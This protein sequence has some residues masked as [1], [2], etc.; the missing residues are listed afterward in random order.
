MAIDFPP[1]TAHPAAPAVGEKWPQPSVVGVPVYSWDGEK[2]T[3]IGGEIGSIGGADDLPLMDGVATPGVST[4]WA[5]EDHVHPT[6]TS[7]ASINYVNTTVVNTVTRSDNILCPHERLVI[8]RTD[9]TTVSVAADAVMLF[10]VAADELKR[11][12]P[13][14]KSPVITVSG[15]NGL[16]SGIEAAGTWYNIWAIGK[17]DCFLSARQ[18]PPCQRCILSRD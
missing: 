2:W 15:I 12:G 4:Q 18:R 7:L 11:F 3:T 14:A 6:D 9:D 5:R 8:S 10:D 13:L 16:D 1:N 17:A